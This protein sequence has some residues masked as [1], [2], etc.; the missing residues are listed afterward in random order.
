MEVTAL[1][2]AAATARTEA[3]A[4]TLVATVALVKARRHR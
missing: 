2:E 1:T 4:L 3:M